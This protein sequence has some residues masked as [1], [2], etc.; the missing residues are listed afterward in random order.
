MA[1]KG[2][3]R[4]QRTHTKERNVVPP[5]PEIK[6]SVN[7]LNEKTIPNISGTQSP[8][9]KIFRSKA[10]MEEKPIYQAYPTIDTDL[11]RDN[12]E[13]DITAADLQ[14]T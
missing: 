14:D 6:G 2:M 3:K 1:K 7:S 13:N 9:Q 4:P 8:A 12:I 5:V 11:G 10:Y